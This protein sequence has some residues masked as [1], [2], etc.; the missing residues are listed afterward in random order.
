MTDGPLYYS[1]AQLAE[2]AGVGMRTLEKHNVL[3]VGNI[4]A[5][6]E[7]IPGLGLVYAASKCRKYLALCAA[8]AKRK[9]VTA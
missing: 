2:A 6:R 1:R 7:K 3:N 5:A 9:S 4:Q 8:G